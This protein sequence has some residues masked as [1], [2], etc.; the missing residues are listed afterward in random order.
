MERLQP[1]L[2]CDVVSTV[3]ILKGQIELVLSQ[4]IAAI[5]AVPGTLFS[6]TVTVDINSDMF[7]ELL[8]VLQPIVPG[9]AVT[10]E[11]GHLAGFVLSKVSLLQLSSLRSGLV[12]YSQALWR[13]NNNRGACNRFFPV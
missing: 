9:V 4:Y 10:D 3:G 1:E 11:P 5:R 13:N 12:R 8:C 6:S 7:A 2:L